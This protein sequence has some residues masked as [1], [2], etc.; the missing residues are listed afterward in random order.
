MRQRHSELVLRLFVLVEAFLSPVLINLLILS[1]VGSPP[2]LLTM[3]GSQPYLSFRRSAPA[4]ADDDFNEFDVLYAGRNRVPYRPPRPGAK[5][6]GD[7]TERL[8]SINDPELRVFS[9]VTDGNRS[10]LGGRTT[11]DFMQKY[12]SAHFGIGARG[13]CTLRNSNSTLQIAAP[14]VEET[15][16]VLSGG[17]LPSAK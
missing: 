7:R 12:P 15:P 9:V 13:I 16:S 2:I 4:P 17:R 10:G 3:A 8:S 5:T 1:E 14:V 6:L 11:M